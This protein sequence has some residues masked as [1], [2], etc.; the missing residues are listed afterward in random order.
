M[1]SK[2]SWL[3]LKIPPVPLV[4]IFMLVMWLISAWTPGIQ[5]SSQ[6]RFIAIAASIGIGILYAASGVLSFNTARTTVNPLTPDKSSSLVTSGIY[7]YTRNPMYVGFSFLLLGFGVYL[8]NLYSLASTVV[9]VM[10]MNKFQ[11]RPE[12]RALEETFGAAFITYKNQVRR[13]L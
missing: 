2:R 7:R 12:E 1:E 6:T 13:W 8:S 10:Y 3:E 4:V 5:I 9:F 11:I